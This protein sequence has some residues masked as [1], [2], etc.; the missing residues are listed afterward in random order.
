[1]ER[2]FLMIF[3]SAFLFFMAQPAFSFD[4]NGWWSRENKVPNTPELMKITKERFSGIK[5]S[6]ISS[7]SDETK[8]SIDNGGPTIIKRMSDDKISV[9]T[10]NKNVLIYKC[11][12]RDT[13]ISQEEAERL[14]KQH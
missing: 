3:M 8:I 5:Y 4:L 1:M 10:V 14:T 2:T 11:V 7:S 12:S 13:N 6:V 9:T